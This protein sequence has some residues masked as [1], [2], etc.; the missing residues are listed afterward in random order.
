MPVLDYLT[1]L[2][3]IGRLAHCGCHH[4]LDQIQDYVNGERELSSNKHSFPSSS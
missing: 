4:S 2:I 3:E 1:V